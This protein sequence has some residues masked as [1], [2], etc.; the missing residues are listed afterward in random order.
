MERKTHLSRNV[1]LKVQGANA[2]SSNKN[3]EDKNRDETGHSE[4]D[5]DDG[6]SE[7]TEEETARFRRLMTGTEIDWSQVPDN[8]GLRL[9]SEDSESSENLLASDTESESDNDT[10]EHISLTD[11]K[12][13]SDKNKTQDSGTKSAA[14]KVHQNVPGGSERPYQRKAIRKGKQIVIRHLTCCEK[15]F[16]RGTRMNEHFADVHPERSIPFPRKGGLRNRNV[17][18]AKR[19][20]KIKERNQEYYKK[21]KQNS[22]KHVEPSTE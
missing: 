3:R 5:E 17:D 22:V 9:Q 10:F 15:R 2:H 4:V 14:K 18:M 20:E 19:K 8:G 13:V 1:I 16:K 11:K 6:H 7:W 12:N 21:I